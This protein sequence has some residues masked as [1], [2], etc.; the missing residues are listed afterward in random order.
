[1]LDKKEIYYCESCE[2]SVAKGKYCPDCGTHNIGEKSNFKTLIT[3]SIS[4]VFSFEKGLYYNFKVTF[5]KPHDIVWSYY[6]GIR[7]KYAAPGRFFLYT[8]FFL[9]A[10]YLIDPNFGVLDIS[11][12]NE[13]TSALT[14]TKLF[15]ILI[16]PLLSIS[17]K[18]VFWKNKGMAL[19]ILSM[20]YLFLPR[21]VIATVL[22]TILN[23]SFESNWFQLLVFFLAI[24]HT[25]WSN[26]L[27]QRGTIS[28][29]QKVGLT[30]LQFL[31]LIGLT[32][33]ILLILVIASGTSLT[34]A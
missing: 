22:I 10:L 14:G 20:I 30:I 4:E 1:M 28:T 11:I 16:I 2:N 27:V 23:I 33:L 8:L 12:N 18:I 9:G 17:S 25:M 32:L 34:V 15:L 31:L 19:H 24:L 7:N 6:N 21:F 3:N 29:L 13:S 5:T 26:A